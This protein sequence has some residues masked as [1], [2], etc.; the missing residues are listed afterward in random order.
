M[1]KSAHL[2]VAVMAA[3]SMELAAG[4]AHAQEAASGTKQPARVEPAD[5][6]TITVTGSLLPTAPDAVAV[7]VIA[8]DAKQLEQNGVTTNAL[9]ML[10]KAI[11]S[12]AGRSNAGTS[13]ANNDNQR[14]AGGSQLQ[15]RNLPTLILVDGRRVAN[16]GVGG[17]NGKNFVDV[18]QI[19]AAAIDHIEVLTDGASSIYGSDAIGGVVNFILKSNYKGVNAGGRYAFAN[20]DYKERSGYITAGTDLGPLS[21]TAT[22][23]YSKTSPLFQSARAFTSPLYNKTSSIPGVVAVGSNNPGGILAPGINSPGAL[24]P[25]GTAATATSVNQLIANGTYLPTTPAAVAAGFDVSPYQTLLLQQELESFVSSLKMKIFDGRAELF[26][27]VMLSE[28]RSFT[29][30]LPVPAPGLTV[31]ANAPSNPLTGNFGGVT[32][33]D[34][35]APKQFFNNVKAVRLTAGARGDIVH[36]WT[37]ETGFVFSQSDL[38][39]DQANLLYKPNIPLAI[40]GGYDANGNAVVG[41]AYSKVHSGFSLTGPLVLQAALDP[42]ARAGALNPA[43]LA[44]LYGTEFINARSALTSFDLQVVGTLFDLPAGKVGLAVGGS[45]RRES[46]SGR[47]DNNGRVTDPATGLVTGNAQQWLGGTYADPFD[48]H[49]DID[50]LFAETRLPITSDAW[51]VP[52]VEEFDLTAAVRAEKYSDAGRSTVPKIGFR[53]Q[54]F[55]RQFTVRG[56]YSKSFSAPSLYAEYGPT[57][58]RQVGAGVIQGVFGANYTG[59]PFNGEDG[60]NPNLRPARS[61]SR[62]IGFVFQP[63]FIK[64]L[65]VSADY[66]AITL[67]GFA[68]GIGFNN[69][70]ASINK[71]GA[72]SPFFNNLGVDN[73]VGAAGASQPFVNPGDLQKFLTNAATLQGIPAQANRLYLIDQFRNLAVLI[74]HAY[75]I[76]ASYVIPSERAGT[77][78]VSTA[79]AIFT[80]F[81]FQDLP[82]NPFVQYAGTTNNSGGSGGFGGTL[83]KYRFFTTFDWVYNNVDVTLSNTYVSSTVDTGVNGTSTP[84]IPV[85][86]YYTFDARAAYDFPM[87]H[88]NEGKITAAVGVNNIADRMP[89]LAPRA[90]LDNN[91]DVSTFSPIGRLI[92]ATLSVTF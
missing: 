61:Q 69:I 3:C 76:E 67:N 21:I 34:L 72:A 4:T 89:P 11:P 40:A 42:F 77:F 59:M 6:E 60:N 92:Y 71:L 45:V 25:T 70:L 81:N 74:E 87:P 12:F 46:L 23:S 84:T 37:W 13:N 49:R 27:D 73:F 86:S 35:G 44:N 65:S 39:Q 55:D 16:S 5:L 22:G 53:W 57:D 64:G 26:S 58:T 54:P 29:Q 31:P 75:S 10:R 20:G 52:G 91:A 8:I 79:G 30:W 41:G 63:D 17:I 18:N 32:F 90:F 43:S 15:L 1:Q 83:P 9:E 56:N 78:T 88:F 33:D 38:V 85:A 14:T 19:P 7:P 36:G 28:S 66:S 2:G 50:A 62:S 80:S 51:N 48:R 82:G 24:N 47:A 68:G